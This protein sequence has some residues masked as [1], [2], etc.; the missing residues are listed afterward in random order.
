M[1]FVSDPNETYNT[2]KL[3]MFHMFACIQ[4]FGAHVYICTELLYVSDTIETYNTHIR[5]V[6]HVCMYTVMARACL[7]IYRAALCIWYKWDT[8]HARQAC[9]T[10]LHVCRV[11]PRMYA[12]I[13]LLHVSFVFDNQIVYISHVKL[14]YISYVT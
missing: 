14:M 4:W 8:L 13:E 9:F 11:F 10:Y 7:H 6:S 2:H 3:G 12:C 1:P 5:H